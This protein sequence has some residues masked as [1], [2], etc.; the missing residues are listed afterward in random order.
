MNSIFLCY[1]WSFQISVGILRSNLGKLNRSKV[2]VCRAPA[3]SSLWFPASSK[4]LITDLTK[5]GKWKFKAKI[6]WSMQI[7]FGIGL[8]KKKSPNFF[9]V[10]CK[11]VVLQNWDYVLARNLWMKVDISLFMVS[12]FSTQL[13]VSSTLLRCKV[14]RSFLWPCPHTYGLG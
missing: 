10:R 5:I 3:P 11:F 4:N 12:L 2:W 1:L 14:D 7:R 8:F 9:S 6:S 13:K